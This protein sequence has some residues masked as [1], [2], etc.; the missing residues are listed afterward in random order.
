MIDRDD[1]IKIARQAGIVGVHVERDGAFDEQLVA[2]EV[3]YELAVTKEREL[4]GEAAIKAAE[5]AIDVAIKLE[6][7]A[8]ALL[9]EK[10]IAEEY[11]DVATEIRAR[12]QA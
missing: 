7:E 4:Y 2:L 11:Y 8:C 5:K 12:G 9:A 10:L 3:F 6:R 1:I